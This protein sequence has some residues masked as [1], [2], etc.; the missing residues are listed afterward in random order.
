MDK[1]PRRTIYKCKIVRENTQV[2]VKRAFVAVFDNLTEEEIGN[3][4]PDLS[5]GSLVLALQ[6]G[7]YHLIID[8]EG[9]QSHEVD[10]VVK[11]KSDFKDFQLQDFIVTPR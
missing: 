2:I 4:S 10:I 1:D 6:P 11:G 9:Y 7:S 8:A 3:Y 5:T